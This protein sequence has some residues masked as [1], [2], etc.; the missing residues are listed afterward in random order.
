MGAFIE[1]LVGRAA[2]D[3]DIAR[4]ESASALRATEAAQFTDENDESKT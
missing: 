2:V 4:S 1:N 3:G